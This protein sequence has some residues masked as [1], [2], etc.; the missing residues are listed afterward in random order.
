MAIYAKGIGICDTNIQS[1]YNLTNVDL[2][3][4][5]NGGGQTASS[6]NDSTWL[7]PEGKSA[8][9]ITASKSH[10]AQSGTYYGRLGYAYTCPEC[11][12]EVTT[13][14]SECPVCGEPVVSSSALTPVLAVSGGTNDGW[15]TGSQG[16]KILLTRT[17][18]NKAM[19]QGQLKD[20]LSG[21]GFT[22]AYL[23]SPT[24]I[25]SNTSAFKTNVSNNLTNYP[26]TIYEGTYA[27]N[28]AYLHK[29]SFI[30]QTVPFSEP[31]YIRVVSG[32]THNI[33]S[34]AQTI[35]SVIRTNIPLPYNFVS[36]SS[37]NWITSFHYVE[38]L[39]Y[40]DFSL[41]KVTA[42]VS[43]NDSLTDAR[44]GV[45]TI[46]DSTYGVSGAITVSQSAKTGPSEYNINFET[47]VESE[48][49]SSDDDDNI[50]VHGGNERIYITGYTAA[51]FFAASS[52][53]LENIPASSLAPSGS[54]DY[55]D[56]NITLTFNFDYYLGTHTSDLITIIS[57][58]ST[59]GSITFQYG[60]TTGQL[61]FNN[62]LGTESLIKIAISCII[63][64]SA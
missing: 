4:V 40:P 49:L 59:E 7:V 30:P 21:M 2:T 42:N 22:S 46:S 29:N 47:S 53:N 57:H 28:K 9:T 16:G 48:V 52:F 60:V 20:T 58:E 15:K 54:G 8:C 44:S 27:D 17:N 35:N 51:K 6:S 50:T 25:T 11:G 34:S 43:E 37:V 36:A 23:N 1:G 19:T 3:L 18:D 41:I 56:T 32:K 24:K 63:Q 31:Y 38:D 12:G 64:H 10:Y 33:T 55:G 45:I 39:H 5:W 62:M 61:H 14:D 13:I 26:V